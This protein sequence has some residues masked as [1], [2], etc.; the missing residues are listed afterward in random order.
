MTL[1][2]RQRSADGA[3]IDCRATCQGLK[4]SGRA[5]LE[6]HLDSKLWSTGC[7]SARSYQYASVC[8]CICLAGV[9]T[10]SL[11]AGFNVLLYRC[12]ARLIMP[13]HNIDEAAFTAP[14]NGMTMEAGPVAEGASKPLTDASSTGELDIFWKGTT[15]DIQPCCHIFGI[16]LQVPVRCTICSIRATKTYAEHKDVNRCDSIVAMLRL[17]R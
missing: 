10:S 5:K 13:T 2:K 6:P 1:C 4:R 7:W 9:C 8:Q 16:P 15:P 14:P 3:L 11:C 17:S 12:Q